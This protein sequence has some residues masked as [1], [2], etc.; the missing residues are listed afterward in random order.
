MR[1][2]RRLSEAHDRATA[3]AIGDQ[4]AE[5]TRRQDHCF[6]AYEGPVTLDLTYLIEKQIHII[7][8]L[9]YDASE[10]N[11][12][13]GLMASG[14]VDRKKLITHTF[15]VDRIVEAFETQ[16]RGQAIKVMIH[17]TSAA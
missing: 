10:L 6:G 9:G 1:R 13:L 7:G 11:Q 14:K 17:P 8:S 15:P 3:A 16:G 12:G 4:H 5:A 2:L